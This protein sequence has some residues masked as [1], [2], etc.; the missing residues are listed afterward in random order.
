MSKTKILR[1]LLQL[2]VIFAWRIGIFFASKSLHWNIVVCDMTST[3][4]KYGTRFATDVGSVLDDLA[5]TSP[6]LLEQTQQYVHYIARVQINNRFEYFSSPRLLLLCVDYE[7]GDVNQRASIRRD[8]VEAA[9]LAHLAG[10]KKKPA[11]TWS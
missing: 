6:Q 9:T 4:S 10:S 2:P 1:R 8:I 3:Q 7:N 11:S 5:V